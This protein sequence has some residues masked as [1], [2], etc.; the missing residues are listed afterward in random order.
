MLP[1]RRLNLALDRNSYLTHVT[2]AVTCGA[3][4]RVYWNSCTWSSSDALTLLC[5]SGDIVWYCISVY[6]NTLE[7]YFKIFTFSKQALNES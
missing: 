5:Q 6:L 2:H 3:F 7:V 4:R 1:A